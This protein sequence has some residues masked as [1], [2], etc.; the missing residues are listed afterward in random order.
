MVVQALG[1]VIRAT[2]SLWE[3]FFLY[4]APRCIIW[5]ARIAIRNTFILFITIVCVVR[6][7]DILERKTDLSVDT[8]GVS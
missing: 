8:E 3:T 2:I 7:T 4:L 6:A 5:A 1:C